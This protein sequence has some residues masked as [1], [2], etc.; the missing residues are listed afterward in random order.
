MIPPIEPFEVRHANG[1]GFT[2]K[3]KR[4]GVFPKVKVRTIGANPRIRPCG[5][6]A[7]TVE[8]E[9][10]P[11]NDTMALEQMHWEVA[12]RKRSKDLAIRE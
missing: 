6:N 10:L 2:L 7:F 11:I 5:S 4:S 3:Y 12:Q 8:N 9:A 1:A